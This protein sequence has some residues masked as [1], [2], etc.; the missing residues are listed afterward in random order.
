MLFIIESYYNY[1]EIEIKERIKFFFHEE[2]TFNIFYYPMKCLKSL[3]LFSLHLLFSEHNNSNIQDAF[4]DL[5]KEKGSFR[6]LS[7]NYAVSFFIICL[8]L[9][10]DGK[11]PLL[12]KYLINGTVWLCDRY[13]GNGLSPVGFSLNEEIE[14]LLSEILDG[15][16]YHNRKTS[17]MATIILDIVANLKDEELYSNISNDLRAV[18]IIPEYYH[19]N[20][21]NELYDYSNN[22]TQTDNDFSLVLEDNYTQIIKYVREQC[23][24]D[25]NK[26]EMLL[27]MFSLRD[28]YFPKYIYEVIKDNLNDIS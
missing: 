23:K 28:R 3:E 8:V 7:D 17:F 12:K 21:E 10:R 2:G 16:K 11:I 9:I 25:L 26:N 4:Y 22:G 5:L 6:V 20:N 13:N 14:Q 18:N 15:F 19:V 24:L 27:I 1:Y